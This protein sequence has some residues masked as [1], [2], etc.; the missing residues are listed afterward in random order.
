MAGRNDIANSGNDISD[1][2]MKSLARTLFPIIR[3]YLLSEQGQKDYAEWKNRQLNTKLNK[4]S[5]WNHTDA[6]TP[7]RGENYAE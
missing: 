6:A 5:D 4:I 3:D 2:D 1:M 7:G